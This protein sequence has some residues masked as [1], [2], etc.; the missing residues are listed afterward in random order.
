ML[1][2]PPRLEPFFH[3]AIF[4]DPVSTSAA[5]DNAYLARKN[6]N[7]FLVEGHQMAISNCEN[8]DS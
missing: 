7:T 3:A 5:I 1:C 8:V 4:Y 2:F 6:Q